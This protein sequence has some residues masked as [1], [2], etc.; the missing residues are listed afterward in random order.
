MR[1]LGENSSTAKY[2]WVATSITHDQLQNMFL[3]TTKHMSYC[4]MILVVL[5]I[6]PRPR[7]VCKC[8][9]LLEVL[10]RVLITPKMATS[11]SSPTIHPPPLRH[12]LCTTHHPQT[13]IHSPIYPTEYNTKVGDSTLA[14]RVGWGH[15][16]GN[17]GMLLASTIHRAL[18]TFAVQS[19]FIFR[20]LSQDAASQ[21][22]YR[23]TNTINILT[24]KTLWQTE[25]IF[26]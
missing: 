26:L 22:I 12:S 1:R 9:Y 23:S 18:V 15:G 5:A 10:T 17:G 19:I 25:C 13:K 20:L 11:R 3:C 8:G 2:H 21:R 16:A 7:K 14:P 6:S 4:I 24:F